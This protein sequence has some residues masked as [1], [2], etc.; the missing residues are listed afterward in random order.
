MKLYPRLIGLSR[1]DCGILA[2]TT[3]F[4]KIVVAAAGNFGARK[5][6][7]S[8]AERRAHIE[9]ISGSMLIQV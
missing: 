2:A 5:L 1:H 4:G 8:P 7:C 9:S 3:A 6:A